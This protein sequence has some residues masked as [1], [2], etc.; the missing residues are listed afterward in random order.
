MKSTEQT[1][2]LW[3]EE[4]VPLERRGWKQTGCSL[5]LTLFLGSLALLPSSSSF[6]STSAAPEGSQSHPPT[7]V[8]VSTQPCPR[9]E[10]A[11]QHTRIAA[12]ENFTE[13]LQTLE[14][15]S[16]NDFPC[17]DPSPQARQG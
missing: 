4:W 5:V 10:G 6:H 7:T 13:D 3:Q 12:K 8:P 11:D 1:K 2:G 9:T 15:P 14:R 17:D 16:S